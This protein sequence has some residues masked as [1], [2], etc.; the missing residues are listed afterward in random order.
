MSR[1]ALLA[2]CLWAGSASAQTAPRPVA[3][4]LE[5]GD[6]DGAPDAVG[7]TVT[8]AG[9]ATVAEGTF[10]TFGARLFIEDGTAG[11]AVR[12]EDGARSGRPVAAGDSLVVT[13]P[14]G[15]YA[16]VGYVSASAVRHVG[17]GPAPA[18]LDYDPSRADALEGRLVRAEGT[19]VGVS[20]VA[21][22][23]AL[24][25]SLD[26]QSLVVAFAFRDQPRPV[27][28]DDLEAGDRV[29]VTGVAGQYDRSPPYTDSRQIYPR[30]PADVA[31]VGLSASDYR[32]A[33]SSALLAL[34]VVTGLAV[35]FRVQVRRRVAALR[36]SEDR[37]HEL[38]GRASDAVFVHDLDGA[39]AEGNHAAHAALGTGADGAPRP[40]LEAVAAES[41][42]AAQAHLE[43]LAAD[44]I[45]RSD[46]R[47]AHADG[48]LFEVESQVAT[49]DGT[50]RALSLGRD[51]DERRAYEQELIAAREEAENAA[52]LKS[53]F[54]ANM[55]HEIRTPLTAVI[56]FA[57]LLRD[58][59]ADDQQ[60][61]VQGI[62]SGGRRLLTTLN[63][64]LDLAALDAREHALTPVAT[65]L[66]AEAREVAALLRP[67]AAERG[68]ALEVEAPA[69]LAAVAD[70]DAFGR[71]L[72][73]LVGNAVKFT[74][75]GGVTVGLEGGADAVVLRVADTG[76]GISD[77]FLPRL[78][79]AF[80]QASE[81]F[82]RSHEGSGLGLT[83]TQ[84]LVEEMGGA[85][86]VESAV[87]VGTVFTVT[88]PRGLEAAGDGAVAEPALA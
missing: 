71:V 62:D 87:G 63:S 36:A 53:S 25:V 33:A 51:V 21:A 15:F 61:L 46:L 78:F 31:L 55:S 28:F 17:G 66:A 65:D 44:G 38:V 59:V 47:M 39:R 42:P 40:L 85:I 9:R 84:R 23:Q 79:A 73:N 10:G 43:A 56:G 2:V 3:A 70:P 19:V 26:D 35:W 37:Y 86:G 14:L 88:L 77:E 72:T 24:M 54:L 11:I 30:S 7:D 22:G 41:R 83:I 6:G 68:L 60:D 8:V 50:R 1:L 52:R 12:L 4:V 18:A 57:E 69:T 20:T 64:I 49:V 81:G 76:V 16:G 32:R 5:D 58:E 82:G 45:A 34:L 27:P 80:R 75:A 74:D 29:R 13:G 48:R 67:L